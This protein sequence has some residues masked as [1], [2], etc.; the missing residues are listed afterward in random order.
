MNRMILW[1]TWQVSTW[2]CGNSS[3][4]I[5]SLQQVV[6]VHQT[7]VDTYLEDI[8]LS[9]MDNTADKQAREEI[10]LIAQQINQVAYDIEDR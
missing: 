5:C 9:S 3:G 10:Q 7:S 1:H 4:C 6:K 2:H 8:I